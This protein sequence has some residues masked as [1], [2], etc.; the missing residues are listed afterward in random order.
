[1]T[2]LSPSALFLAALAAYVLI[3]SLFRVRRRRREISALFLWEGLRE[4][5]RSRTIR[6]SIPLDLL[7][8]LQLLVLLALVVALAEP[9]LTRRTVGLSDLAVVIDGSASMGTQT[10]G[11]MS[12]YEQAVERA[13]AFIEENR[14][15]RTTILQLTSSPRVLL[16]SAA[17][18]AEARRAL[19]RSAPTLLA[20]GSIDDLVLALGPYGGYSAFERVVVFSDRLLAESG[21]DPAIEGYTIGG[22]KNWSIDAFSVRE[23]PN[24]PGVHAFVKA[25]NHS[26]ESVRMTLT[27]DDGFSSVD[28]SL[29]LLPGG[30]ESYVLPFPSSRSSTF[31]ATLTPTDDLPADNIRYFSLQRP[32]DLRIAWIG[33]ESRYLLSAMEASA[34]LIIGSPSDAPDLTVVYREAPPMD[35][36]GNILLVNA[37]LPGHVDLGPEGPGGRIIALQPDHP[38]LVGVDEMALRVSSLPSV[39]SMAAG[40]VVLA[41]EETPLLVEFE[42]EARIVT[43][44]GADLLSTN[45]PITVDF[46]L[47]VRNILSRVARIPATVTH[48]WAIAG[49]PVL[50]GESGERIEAVLAP[51]GHRFV[52]DSNQ[53]LFI[54][55]EVGFYE[56]ESD[57]GTYVVGVNVDPGESTEA[58]VVES[59]T[60]VLVQQGPNRAFLWPLWPW[61]ALA[62]F[63]L[64][65]WEGLENAG[66]RLLDRRS[67]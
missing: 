35:L 55:D 31:T 4:D 60:F 30:S 25:S 24:G 48:T 10:E 65:V 7:L 64:L 38:L 36:A 13:V 6:R 58:S 67:S 26:E 14:A 39:E 49:D 54:P 21:V 59:D 47:L 50:L 62:A 63:A 16:E 17:R 40:D 46:P 3:L 27:V 20:D 37:G 23:N 52:I 56:L 41:A 44:F 11:G 2:F 51:D 19:E 57:R 66:V 29:T 12:R 18:P 34:P 22:G 32:I 5:P 43:F 1:V 53:L 15:T 8:L 28:L 42:D 61:F 33:E 45:L 9:A